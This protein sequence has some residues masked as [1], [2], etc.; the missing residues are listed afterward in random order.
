MRRSHGCRWCGRPDTTAPIGPF[1]SRSEAATTATLLARFTGVRTCTAR[2]ARSALHGPSCP[3]LEVSPCPAARGVTAT[4]YAAAVARAVALIDGLDNSAL[5]AAVHQ[6]GALA[7][8]L[9]LRE[10]RAPA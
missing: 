3:E 5:G 7:E 6:V 9:P 2:L 4:Q 10:R 8:A 1:R